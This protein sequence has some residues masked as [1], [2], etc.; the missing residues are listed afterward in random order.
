MNANIIQ[1]NFGTNLKNMTYRGVSVN[2]KMLKYV[3]KC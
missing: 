1:L 2:L 3:L